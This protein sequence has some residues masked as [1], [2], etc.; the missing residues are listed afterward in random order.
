MISLKKYYIFII[1]IL[2]YTF[3]L[4]IK[5]PHSCIFAL[6]TIVSK[7]IVKNKKNVIAF[8]LKNCPYDFTHFLKFNKFHVFALVFKWPN[9]K[10][11]C[12]KLK[13]LTK[14]SSAIWNKK[15]VFLHHL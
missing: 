3:F 15:I 10:F 5:N 8:C 7:K 4:I 12:I 6:F 14:E 1:F 11:T 9:R 13:T 2:I